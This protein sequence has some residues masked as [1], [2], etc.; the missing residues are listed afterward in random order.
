M[1][2]SQNPELKH[3]DGCCS[4]LSVDHLELPGQDFWKET[5]LWSVS[6]VCDWV[7][8]P[9]KS[10]FLLP[11]LSSGLHPSQEHLKANYVTTLREVCPC[12]KA[13][14]DAPSS[15]CFWGM[16][17]HTRFFA[18]QKIKK[19]RKKMATSC[20]VDHNFCGCGHSICVFIC[21]QSDGRW[22]ETRAEGREEKTTL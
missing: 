21:E 18:Y 1:F 22:Q 20:G 19:E 14:T 2:T 16:W 6:N 3:G 7:N 17:P 4:Q 12:P 10:S 11:C 9:F 13:P 5:S 15:P 8:C